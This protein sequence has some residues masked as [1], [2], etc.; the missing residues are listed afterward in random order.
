MSKFTPQ[1]LKHWQRYEKVRAKGRW[2]MFDH[3]AR[4]ATGLDREEYL[5]VMQ[6]YEELETAVENQTKKGQ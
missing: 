3:A 6:N 2:N 4:L 5:F 1:Q